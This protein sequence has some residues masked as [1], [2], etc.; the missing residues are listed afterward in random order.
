M[1]DDLIVFGDSVQID[2]TVDGDLIS[3][4]RNLTITGHVTGDVISLGAFTQI[5]GTVDG[6]V[7]SFSNQLMFRGKIGKNLMVF[8]NQLETD[9]QSTIGWGVD[10]FRDGDA[11]LNG[12]IERDI[13]GFTRHMDLNGFVGGNTDLKANDSFTVGPQAQTM[14]KIELH[15]SVQPVISSGAQLAS[16][17]DTTIE[18]HRADWFVAD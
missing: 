9:A 10:H 11:T 5:S 16:P 18:V 7:R 4:G 8:T 14:G 1:K 2:G 15:G 12:H 17:V 6:S 13:L 3:F